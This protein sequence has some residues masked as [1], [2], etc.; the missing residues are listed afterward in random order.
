[1]AWL[2]APDSYRDGSSLEKIFA[3]DWKQVRYYPK[4]ADFVL[5]PARAAN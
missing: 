5:D 2:L 3:V 1:M 4:Y